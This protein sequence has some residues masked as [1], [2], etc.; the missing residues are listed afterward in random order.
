LAEICQEQLLLTTSLKIFLYSQRMEF[1]LNP[2][3]EIFRTTL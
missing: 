3:L 1:L 2:G